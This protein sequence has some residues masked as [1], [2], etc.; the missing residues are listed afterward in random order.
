M[1]STF[2]YT[3][4][5]FLK[6]QE[7]KTSIVV[8]IIVVATIFI[9]TLAIP[10]NA[11]TNVAEIRISRIDDSSIGKVVTV[12]GVIV[13]ISSNIEPSTS[14]D[15]GIQTYEPGDTSILTI[16]D[17]TDKI[18]VSSEPVIL[19]GF[20][21]GE[22]IAVTGIYAGKGGI[23]EG[24]GIIY[25]NEVSSGIEGGYK[26]VTIAELIGTPKYYY[27]DSVRIKGNVIGIELTSG[28]TEL[29]IEEDT[30]TMD[31]EYGAEIEDIKRG[32]EVVVEGK[33]Y[34]N[35]IYAFAVKT[36]KP[37]FEVESRPTPTPGSSVTETPTPTPAP[38]PAPSPTPIEEAGMPTYLMVIIIAVVVVA[39]VF[40]AFKAREW[41][42][43][44]RYGK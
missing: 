2:K 7:M 22:K 25:A 16:Y 14:K 19:E 42:M 9:V 35:K 34:W 40:I 5:K 29:V 44:R 27:D 33:F 36:S 4:F 3:C 10:A 31:V 28:E 38:T 43:L 8:S 15:V 32:D 39:G 11:D 24:K 18:F 21:M 1:N 17:G 6:L 41:L 30:K 23:T 37:E 20:P 13:A 12:S 26:D